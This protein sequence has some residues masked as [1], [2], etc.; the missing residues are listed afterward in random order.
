MKSVQKF[1]L[2]S[3]IKGKCIFTYLPQQ[4]VFMVPDGNVFILR[5]IGDDLDEATDFCLGVQ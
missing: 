4:G 5:S 1:I 2:Y 3:V